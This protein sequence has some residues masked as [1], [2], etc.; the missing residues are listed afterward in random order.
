MDLNR[1]YLLIR[2]NP[3]SFLIGIIV[4]GV[5]PFIN[6]TFTTD[7]ELAWRYS[8]F[9][10]L[11]GVI[12]FTMIIKQKPSIEIPWN[13]VFISF[14]IY[15]GIAL[16]SVSFSLIKGEGLYEISKMFLMGCALL[17]F[18]KIFR[19]ETNALDICIFFISIAILIFSGFALSQLLP[20]VGTSVESG[21]PVIIR[22]HLSSTLANKNFFAETMLLCLP[23][24]MYGSGN[25][26][27]LIRWLSFISVLSI[28]AWILILQSIS[29]LIALC[30][31][32]MVYII[33]S[34]KYPDKNSVSEPVAGTLKPSLLNNVLRIVIALCVYSGI[35]FFYSKTSN[36]HQLVNKINTVRYYLEEPDKIFI[37][38][39]E[40][41]NNSIFERFLLIRNSW[42]MFKENP[43][44][45]QGIS[46]WKIY[47]P[48]YGVGGTTFLTF[49]RI[50]FEHPHN[51]YLQ[52]MC[53]TG[54][55]GLM[56]WLGIFIFSIRTL[57]RNI[58][59]GRN[60]KLMIYILCGLIAFMIISLFGYPKDRFFS[61]LLFVLML[62]VI[63]SVTAEKSKKFIIEK[64]IFFIILTSLIFV[65]SI[66]HAM[67][68]RSEI[69][70]RMGQYWQ[71]QKKF[72]KMLLYTSHSRTFV[73][74]LD[75]TSTPL[76]W[77]NGLARYYMNDYE[78]AFQ[79][80]FKAEKLN[81][82]HMQVVNDL[83]SMYEMRGDHFNSVKCFHRVLEINP[84][85]AMSLQNLSSAKFNM[86]EVDSAFYYLQ[87]Y[88][89]KNTKK[90]RDDMKVILL[91]KAQNLV[92]STRDTSLADHLN[93]QL[94]RQPNYLLKKLDSAEV[95]NI[96]FEEEIR[97]RH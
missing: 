78:G 16:V 79:E 86:G 72:D 53:E 95:K 5:F 47:F 38:D 11:L 59:E 32:V 85:F 49:G 58:K 66:G 83:G 65:T 75:I 10:V 1:L 21:T 90:Y 25:K 14:L 71:I 20:L 33:L 82:Y 42:L 30:C 81:P 4:F 41:N 15:F 2:K 80:Y 55:I 8:I 48:K 62:S 97:I 36:Y 24:C 3:Y 43:V 92:Q 18:I 76:Y 34:K 50:R 35:I 84:A 69:Y 39:D 96:T 7:P 89:Y 28:F 6:T 13:P 64:R 31:V 23:F 57:I 19:S 12:S 60:R 29:V 94:K 40:K 77:Y 87:K 26:L 91:V 68:V 93:A 70:L 45:G 17:F 52:V 27:K 67:R 74:Q 46:D 22:D 9:S 51:V 37:V 61:M 54:I 44:T 73:H 63:L 56:A 88:P